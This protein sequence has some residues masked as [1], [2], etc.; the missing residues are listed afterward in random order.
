VYFNTTKAKKG[1]LGFV[2]IDGKLVNIGSK[3]R[4]N[5]IMTV[6]LYDSANH[7]IG[8]DDRVSTLQL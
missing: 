1:I 4:K 7:T 3:T 6:L 8:S 2:E 5:F